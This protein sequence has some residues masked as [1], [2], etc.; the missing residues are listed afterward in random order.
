MPTKNEIDSLI[1]K[2]ELQEVF[3]DKTSVSPD[4]IPKDRSMDNQYSLTQQP[5]S[6]VFKLF[7]FLTSI[8]S[9]YSP[10]TEMAGEETLGKKIGHLPFMGIGLALNFFGGNKKEEQS[11]TS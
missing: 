8:N 10:L 7:D 5:E 6:N 11:W 9:S 1:N 3:A 2:I 4:E